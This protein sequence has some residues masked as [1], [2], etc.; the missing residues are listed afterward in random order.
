MTAY[1]HN[2]VYNKFAY[3]AI[4]HRIKIQLKCE[5]FIKVEPGHNHSYNIA[6]VHR[7]DFDQAAHLRS[8][9][10]AVAVYWWK[11]NISVGTLKIPPLQRTAFQRYQK[12]ERWVKGLKSWANRASR[13]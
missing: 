7:E 4:Q 9:I 11:N 8:L 13:L 6:C 1:M 12:N 10:R 2:N 5:Q 3:Q